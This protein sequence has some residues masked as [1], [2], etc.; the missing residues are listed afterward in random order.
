MSQ[1]LKVQTFHHREGH[2]FENPAFGE[3]HLYVGNIDLN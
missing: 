2:G 1:Y 3:V